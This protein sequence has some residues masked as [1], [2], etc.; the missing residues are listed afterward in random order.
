M[1]NSEVDPPSISVK[2]L[3]K[4]LNDATRTTESAKFSSQSTVSS[5]TTTKKAAPRKGASKQTSVY[6]QAQTKA[7]SSPLGKTPIRPI[8]NWVAEKTGSQKTS[9]STVATKTTESKPASIER[10]SSERI[11]LEIENIINGI[12]AK[13]GLEPLTISTSLSQKAKSHSQNIV[14]QS[15]FSHDVNG[16]VQDRVPSDKFGAAY[17]NI[18]SVPS[19][20]NQPGKPQHLAKQIVELWMESDGHR[21]NIFRKEIRSYGIGIKTVKPDDSAPISDAAR[22]SGQKPKLQGKGFN[23]LIVTMIFTEKSGV[24]S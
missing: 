4:S 23:Q 5:N 15:R 2:E 7:H 13:A 19:S 20:T 21:Q 12:R 6:A 11:G 22:Q 3:V 24:V 9:V 10:P 1:I 17:E 8:K 14:S 18:A 16:G